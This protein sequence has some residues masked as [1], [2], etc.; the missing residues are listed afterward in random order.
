MADWRPKPDQEMRTRTRSK[1]ISE[2]A[3]KMIG[4]E[5][6]ERDALNEAN[7]LNPSLKTIASGREETGQR[8]AVGGKS[9][10]GPLRKEENL[11]EEGG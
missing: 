10:T 3:S 5:G 6:K 4:K 11:R 7:S 9:W 1:Q 2:D 8:G